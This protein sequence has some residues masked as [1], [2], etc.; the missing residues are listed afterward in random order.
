MADPISP[1]SYKQRHGGSGSSGGVGGGGGGGGGGGMSEPRASHQNGHTS[2]SANGQ[3][4]RWRQNYVPTPY[5]PYKATSPSPGVA[6]V[7]TGGG[8]V[9]DEE[10]G[11]WGS[12]AEF[13]LSCIGL[14]VGIGNVW[15]FP[16]LAYE[17]GGAAFLFP[18]IILLVLIGKPMYLMET[19][20]GQYSQLGP[21]NV[22]RCAPVMQGVGVAM[23]ILSLITAIYYNQL[24]AY[25]LFYMFDCFASDVPWATCDA[26][27][28]DD[29]CFAVG[30]IYPCARYNLTGPTDTINCTLKNESSAVQFWERGVLN[31]DKSGLK[32]FGQIGDIQV[33][34]TLYLLLSWVIVFLCLMKG[35]KS[36]GKVV[37]F[38][39]T[40]PYII[41]IALLI[42]GVMLEGASKGLTF[43]FVPK[44]EKILDVHVWRKAAEQMFF[45][46]SVSWGGLIMFG[47]Y[48]K[49]RNKVHIDA[50]IVSSLD[51]VTSLIAAT[52]IFSVLGAMAHDLGVDIE[53]VAASGPG[54]AFIAY[55]EA[56]SRTLPFPQMWASLFFFMLFTLGLDSEFALLETVLTAL[57]DTF[58]STRNQKLKLTALLCVSCFLMG[59]PMC[60]TMGQYIFYLVDSFGGG[61]G[62]LLIAIL[63][64]VGL[65][66]VYGVRRF[67]EDLKFMLGY[68]PSMFW[69][70]CWVFIAPVTLILMFIYS[71]VTWTNPKYGDVEYPDWAI[72]IGW[73][74]AAVSVGMIP[75][76]FIYVVLKRLF[77][78]NIHR[79]FAPADNWGPGDREAR[80][81]LLALK[82]GINMNE[83]K[84][85]IDNPAMDPRYYPQ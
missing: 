57:Y 65:H 72:A 36:S 69:K 23:V 74:L 14:S 2:S 37:Y 26:D 28:A 15:R 83:T 58:P 54:L 39:A 73:F 49:F 29:N 31:I 7:E 67:S 43:L 85:G 44:W 52:A 84:F 9:E 21:M 81:E 30:G 66:W 3:D 33:K 38:T 41:L 59:I 34:L 35:I 25:T 76:V 42:V 48:N 78:G 19:A 77:T 71:A 68:N 62:V 6:K 47:S 64:L 40:F 16:Y 11:H 10:R 80:Q 1:I 45:S 32:E 56:I 20:L 5:E 70:V 24:M 4:E 53:D 55:P 12:K 82:H 50:F 79:V 61:V 17:N 22:W 60:A 46:L 75:L 8:G 27:W 63:E 51:F 18:Y 13:L